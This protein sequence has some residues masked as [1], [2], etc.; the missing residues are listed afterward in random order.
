MLRISLFECPFCYSNVG[1]SCD[2]SV[3]RHVGFLDY[4][5]MRQVLYNSHRS[6]FLLQLH[7]FCFVLLLLRLFL[8]R[9]LMMPRNVT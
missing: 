3:C 2:V 1:I 5:G 9:L 4:A 8:L 7:P 6:F